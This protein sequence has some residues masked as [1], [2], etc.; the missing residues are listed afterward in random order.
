MKDSHGGRE[1]EDWD[2]DFAENTDKTYEVIGAPGDWKS[3]RRKAGVKE[4]G[5]AGTRTGAITRR[6]Q[7]VC[8]YRSWTAVG[9]KFIV[10][11]S[12]G[13]KGVSYFLKLVRPVEELNSEGPS[14]I[15][16]R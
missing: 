13:A 8:S 15:R 1:Q 9:T 3:Q 6:N 5:S 16:W 4:S 14:R 11:L 10:L 7:C 2:T 12:F